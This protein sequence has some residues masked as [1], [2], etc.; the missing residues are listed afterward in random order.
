MK[1]AGSSPAVGLDR[2]G[3]EP[4]L[5]AGGPANLS[6]LPQRGAID[7]VPASSSENT[8]NGI[9]VG[10]NSTGNL[11]TGHQANGNGSNGIVAV[12]GP[13]GNRFEHNSMHGNDIF[14]ANDQSWPSNV[15]IGND[16]L[17]DFPAGMICGVRQAQ[18][19]WQR[20]DSTQ[21]QTESR[22]CS[23]RGAGIPVCADHRVAWDDDQ[24]RRRRRLL[25]GKGAVLAH[26]LTHPLAAELD[27][28]QQRAP[29]RQ[30]EHEAID[31][32]H[33]RP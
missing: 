18:P 16:C 28:S 25:L 29:A 12:P 3:N 26:R 23:R 7:E 2:P 4:F 5:A 20:R 19:P 31:V 17:T 1:V 33:S 32:H 6:S 27:E 22:Y 8:F 24:E 15:R 10:R 9:N 13:T 21:Q 30:P 11:I 14:D